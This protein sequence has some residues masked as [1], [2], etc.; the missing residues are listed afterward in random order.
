[1]QL[2]SA[3]VKVDPAAW[4]TIRIHHKGANIEGFLDDRKL[5][6]VE[7]TTIPEPGGVGVWAKADARTSFDDLTIEPR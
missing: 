6:D 3:D 4:H 7:D 1:V 2:A 5:L